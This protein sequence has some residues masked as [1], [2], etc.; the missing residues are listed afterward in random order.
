MSDADRSRPI[1]V[2]VD[3][4]PS[5]RLAVEWAADEA[6]RRGLPLRLVHVQ[7]APVKGYRS[8]HTLPSW[9]EWNRE[10]DTAGDRVLTD[11][12]DFVRSRQPA[13]QISTARPEGEPARVLGEETR[14]AAMVV[15]GS[16]HLG[17]REELFTAASV[18]LP[19][20]AHSSCPVAVVPEPEHPAPHPYLVVAV[21]GSPHSA[22][23]VDVAFAEAAS[24]GVALRAVYA[25]H[26]PLAGV[27]DEN[28]AV[29]ES[30]RVLAETLAGR[31]ESYPQ[32]RMDQAVLYG[33]P[34]QVLTEASENAT[35]LIVGTRGRGGFGGMLLGS[36]SQGVLRHAHCPV[37][38]VPNPKAGG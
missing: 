34:V 13:L 22:A 17:R 36:V 18:I 21:D 29:E 5:R 19:L 16:W 12:V 4:D 10:L 3:P 27:L 7:V 26:E 11:A 2:G 15:L 38:A 31:A 33:H 6:A 35:A 30:R 28:A 23:A 24:R 14:D 1:V 8:V 32:V 37:I 20:T 9:Q 25:W